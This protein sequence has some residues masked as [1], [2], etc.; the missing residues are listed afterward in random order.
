MR[1]GATVRAWRGFARVR[2]V[3]IVAMRRSMLAYLSIAYVGVREWHLVCVSS[4]DPCLCS[5]DLRPKPA[6]LSHTFV[7]CDLF[8]CAEYPWV[9]HW[10]VN[11]LRDLPCAPP[12]GVQHEVDTEAHA[13][14][15]H[16][17]NSLQCWPMA[18]CLIS[19]IRK[20]QWARLLDPR[21]SQI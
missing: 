11:M 5:D 9:R 18:R 1:L 17:C 2:W 19:R 13:V 16:C 10:P 14:F 7:G 8:S 21:L 4:S 6:R 15:H 20:A 12:L 3:S